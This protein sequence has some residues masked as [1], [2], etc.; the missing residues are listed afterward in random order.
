[1]LPVSMDISGGDI[2]ECNCTIDDSY[3][4]IMGD[5]RFYRAIGTNTMFTFDRLVHE[6]DR[7]TFVEYIAKGDESKPIL[8]RCQLRGDVYRWML[9]YKK[10]TDNQVDGHDLI[11]LRLYDIIVQRHK[12]SLYR[13]NVNKYRAILTQ[14]DEKVFEYDLNTGVFQMYFY[15]NGRSEIIEKDFL[16]AWQQKVLAFDYVEKSEIESFNR[17]CDYIRS[18]ADSFSITFKSKFMTKGSRRDTLNFRGNTVTDGIDRTMV[19]GIITEVG[20]RIEPKAVLF[21]NA[22]NKDSATGILNKKAV[23]DEIKAAIEDTDAT[24]KKQMYLMV[25]DIDDFK[26]VNDTYGHH[27]GDEVILSFARELQRTIGDRGIVGRIGGDEFM[28]LYKDFENIDEVKDA[29]KAVRKRLKLKLAEKKAGYMFSISAGISTYPKDGITYDELFK[30]ADGA[31]YIAKG[32]GKDR[33]IIYDKEMHQSLIGDEVRSGNTNKSAEFMK[34]IDKSD[35]ASQLMI[36]VMEE[37]ES[38]IKPALEELIDRMN[39]HGISVYSGEQ[40]KCEYSLGHYATPMD[41]AQYVLDKKYLER[42]DEYGIN[43]INNAQSLSIDFPC[44]YDIF[45]EHN[46]CSSLQMLIK[47]DNKICALISFDIF[48]EHRRKWSADDVNMVYLVVKAISHARKK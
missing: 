22:A 11:E 44:V 17:L 47:E 28:V 29:L 12:F 21:D 37:G 25:S 48:G 18:G 7:K 3:M 15:A 24:D 9:L 40:F 46:I 36:K 38:A 19:V 14:I 6:E 8:I 13:G 34:P 41:K 31:L 1:M 2:I 32:K 16:D 10:S 4:I 35:F 23:T 5:E 43:I 39:I 45:M 42:F 27:F 30:I 26:S 20:G 33:Y